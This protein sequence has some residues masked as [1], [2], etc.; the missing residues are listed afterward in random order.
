MLNA[1]TVQAAPAN[2]PQ[3]LKS[4]Q[5]LPTDVFS[6]IQ[7][8]VRRGLIA[9]KIHNQETVFQVIPAFQQYVK[10]LQH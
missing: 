4:Y 6:A 2:F 5:G 8:L 3:L 7:S 9:Q 10:N 1:L